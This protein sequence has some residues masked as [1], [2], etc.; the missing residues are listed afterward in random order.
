MSNS[1]ALT[2]KP[3]SDHTAIGYP[4]TGLEDLPRP[5]FEIVS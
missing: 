1:H 4:P 5:T 2:R 3:G